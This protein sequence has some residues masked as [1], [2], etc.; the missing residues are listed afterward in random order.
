MGLKVRVA[1]DVVLVDEDARD[2]FLPG[3]LVESVLEVATVLLLVELNVLIL[4]AVAIESALGG[5]AVG[6]VGL[7]K[8]HCETVS[9]NS[10]SQREATLRI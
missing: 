2:S 8:H 3:Q 10:R 5:L 6:A 9:Q 1:A 4:G 7:A